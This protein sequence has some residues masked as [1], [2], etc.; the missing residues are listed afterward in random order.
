[1]KKLLLLLLISISF[2]TLAYQSSTTNYPDD[3][4]DLIKG[5][6]YVFGEEAK[7]QE[8]YDLL[9]PLAEKGES[10][11]QAWIGTMYEEGIGFLKNYKEAY[12]WY[13]KSAK[14]GNSTG[15]L[16]IIKLMFKMLDEKIVVPKDKDEKNEAMGEIAKIVMKLS[17]N[18]RATDY[19][20]QEARRLWDKHKL[21]KY[22][23]Y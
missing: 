1:M 12:D 21:W 7:L 19:Q 17:E 3:F 8:G 13:E 5:F 22:P 6:S 10:Q 23:Y 20:N 2:T 14:Q 16:K 15:Q 18:P 11:A 4:D 9:F